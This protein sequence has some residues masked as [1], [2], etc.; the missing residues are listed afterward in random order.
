MRAPPASVSGIRNCSGGDGELSSPNPCDWA[1]IRQAGGAA[2]GGGTGPG[3]PGT[4]A[5]LTTGKLPAV[6]NLY[7]QPRVG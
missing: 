4:P 2:S 1:A 6:R 7:N 3:F 5:K